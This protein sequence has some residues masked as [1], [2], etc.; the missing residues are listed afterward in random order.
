MKKILTGAT[1]A[2]ALTACATVPPMVQTPS[3]RPEKTYT[4]QK[5]ERV[6]SAIAEACMEKQSIVES[7][8]AGQVVC[9]RDTS[10][11]DSVLAAM[12]VGGSYGSHPKF[13][14]R[15][16]LI[17]IGGSVRVQ[18]YQWVES[19]N[20]FGRVDQQELNS[21]EQFNNIQTMLENVGLRLAG[22]Q[23]PSRSAN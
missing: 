21:G 10:G 1:L 12:V 13:K 23:T 14:A 20:A 17:D 3:G 9:S 7:A 6:Q 22:G 11:M 8:V 19:T 15:F 5:L 4:G 18:A 2:C 16:T